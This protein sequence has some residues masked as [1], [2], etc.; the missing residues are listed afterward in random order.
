MPAEDHA[1]LK[2]VP[3]EVKEYVETADG[4]EAT[5][6]LEGVSL[7]M[8]NGL[9]R[10]VLSD[11]RIPA[12]RFNP[13]SSEGNDITFNR[14][15][16]AMH[17]EIMGHRVSMVPVTLGREEFS[18]ALEWTFLLDKKNVSRERLDVTTADIDVFDSRKQ[19]LPKSV[20]DRLFPPNI[21]T[22]DYILLACL[23][24]NLYEPAKGEE[25]AFEARLSLGT[26]NQHALYT[27]VSLCSYA[28]VVDED[29]A[30]KA[31]V[32]FPGDKRDFDSLDRQR[33][34]RKGMED[35]PAALRFAIESSCGL[36]V[37]EIVLDAL[38]VLRSKLL[39]I[40]EGRAQLEVAGEADVIFTISH[41]DHTIGNILGRLLYDDCR[42]GGDLLYAGAFV[43]HPLEDAVQIRVRLG[44]VPDKKAVALR[45]LY[46]A[47]TRGV[48]QLDELVAG[49]DKAA[50]KV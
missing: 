45:I 23:Q 31:R 28:F 2:I 12:F 4:K 44:D 41:E 10:T 5:F 49:F 40:S 19:Q 36:R 50:T 20:R 1:R 48:S 29:A 42:P 7:A 8:A 39:G 6:V 34:Y 18:K 46:A 3:V 24:P 22:G 21:V 13:T 16:T 26:Q 32:A 27:A 15:T 43:P 33:C 25:L 30:A 9:R 11:V 47:A 14:N 35:E 17:N 37:S 38:A